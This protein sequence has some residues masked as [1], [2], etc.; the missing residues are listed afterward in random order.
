MESSPLGSS[1]EGMIAMAA[2]RTAGTGTRRTRFGA[3]VAIL[4]LVAST[5]A[6]MGPTTPASAAPAKVSAHLTQTSFTK[7]EASQVRIAYEFSATSRH[8]GYRLSRKNAAKWVTVRTV[9]KKGKFKGAHSKTVKRLFGSKPIAAGRYRVRVTADANA[10]TLKFA[11]TAPSATAVVPN[12]GAWRST[13]VSGSGGLVSVTGISFA[14]AP[15]SKT[16]AN[17][18]YDYTYSGVM[19]PPFTQQCSG[20]SRTYALG[21]AETPI[22]DGQFA[23]PSGSTGA[24]YQ[25]NSVIGGSGSWTGTFDSPTS[26]HGTATFSW[27][28]MGMGCMRTTGSLGPF[29]WTAVQE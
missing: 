11:V 3:G 25:P 9:S 27:G 28:F 2:I 19:L 18:T 17:F 20:S 16:L 6:V 22:S 15:D 5:G 29:P 10:V 26:A 13:S 7:V 14:V 1:R 24:W 8:F 23:G 12:P 21:G 4:A